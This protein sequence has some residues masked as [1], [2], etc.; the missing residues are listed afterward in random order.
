MYEV[1]RTNAATTLYLGVTVGVMPMRWR[2]AE[3]PDVKVAFTCRQTTPLGFFKTQFDHKTGP[4]ERRLQ[5]CTCVTTEPRCII[6]AVGKLACVG[7]D[8]TLLYF[9]LAFSRHLM[10][11]VILV[12]IYLAIT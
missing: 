11:L 10:F 6:Y 5:H 7:M 9:A 1:L 8:L 2:S 3:W 12:C 4:S